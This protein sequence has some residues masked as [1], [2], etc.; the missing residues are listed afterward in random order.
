[1][2]D[3]EFDQLDIDTDVPDC[4]QTNINSNVMLSSEDDLM[5]SGNKIT[6]SINDIDDLLTDWKE[7]E[8]KNDVLNR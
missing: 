5:K 1:M 7:N 3:S 6:N 4:F 2:S 8:D